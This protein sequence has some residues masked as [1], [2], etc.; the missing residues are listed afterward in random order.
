MKDNPPTL[1]YLAYKFSYNPTEN[2]KEARE[3]AL[4][5]MKKH[6]DWIVFCPHFGIDVLLDGKMEWT[7]KDVGLW[8][9]DD[10][11]RMQAGLMAAGFLSRCDIM[12]L[13]C[14]PTYSESHGVTWEFIIANLLN[15]SYRRSN[16]IKIM[17]IHEAMRD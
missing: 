7:E 5:L 8:N 6:P 9:Q 1:V 16:P 10:W 15:R 4:N 17:H 12:V 2:T 11:R 3:M 13:G 14:A